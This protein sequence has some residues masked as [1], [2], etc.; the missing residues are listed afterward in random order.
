MLKT[1]HGPS[2]KDPECWSV[3]LFRVG[4]CPVAVKAEEVGG[5]WPWDATVSVPS[6]TPFVSRIVRRGEAILAVFDLAAQ[7][8]R[9][10]LGGRLLCLIVKHQQGPMAICIDETLP[11]LLTLDASLISHSHDHHPGV[12]G[13]Y[14]LHEEDVSIYS[15]TRLD[16]W[17]KE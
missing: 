11:E 15:F 5:V 10:V 14:R 12:L 1:P 4:G 6:L 7:M 9:G 2:C 13:T 8:H 16:Q 17:L 3:V